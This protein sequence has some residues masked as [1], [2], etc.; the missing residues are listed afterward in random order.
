MLGLGLALVEL[1]AFSLYAILGA[2]ALSIAQAWAAAVSPSNRLR[3]VLAWAVCTVALAL[4]VFIALGL[5]RGNVRH[6]LA[7]GG[8]DARGRGDRCMRYPR[9]P[10]D[11]RRSGDRPEKRVEPTR[12]IGIVFG[13]VQVA[14]GVKLVVW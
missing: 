12:S 9:R 6:L 1:V 10:R 4:P 11:A 3:Y 2:A 7:A 8:R 13:V 14:G 5:R